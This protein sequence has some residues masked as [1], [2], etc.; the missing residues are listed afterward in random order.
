MRLSKS[1]V[2][3]FAAL[4]FG[5]IGLFGQTPTAQITGTVLDSSGAVVPQAEVK[6]TNID[7]NVVSEKDTSDDGA[8][9]IINLLPGNYVLTVEKAGFKTVALPTFQ[10]EVDQILTEKISMQVGSSAETVTVSAST[11]ATLVQRSTTELGTVIEEKPVESLPLNGRNFTSLLILTPGITPISTAQGSGITASDGGVTGIPGTALTKPSIQGQQNRSTI[12]LLDGINNTDFR[13]STYGIEPIVDTIDEFKVQSHNDMAEYGGVAGGVVNVATKPGTNSFHGAGWDFARS[14]IFDARNPF[15]D[16]C[17]SVRCGVGSSSSTPAPPLGYTQQEFGGAAGGPI[18]KNKTFFYVGYEGWRFSKPISSP[19]GIVPTAAELGG[20]FSNSLIG[21]YDATTKAVVPDPIYN[22]FA[23]GTTQF[24]CNS[25]GNPLPYNTT[26]GPG[27]G[28]QVAGTNCAKI[29]TGLINQQLVAA[30]KAYM[31][32]PNFTP[33]ASQEDNFFQNTPE[34]DN[35]NNWQIRLDEH[36]NDKNTVFLRLSQMWLTDVTPVVGNDQLTYSTYH[37]YNFGGAWDHVF[38]SN[39]I[40]EIRAGANFKPYIFYTQPPSSV[41]FSPETTAGFT[42]I[43]TTYG[44]TIGMPSGSYP[45]AGDSGPS[46]RGNPV[47]NAESSLSWIKGAHNLKMGV[48]YTYT[49]RL[50]TNFSQGLTFSA[51]QTSPANSSGNFTATTVTE[52]DGT[53]VP[54]G[55]GLASMLL[56][57]PSAASVSIPQYQEI[58]LEVSSWA[59]YVQDEWHV[60]PKLTVDWGLRYDY[61]PQVSV[62]DQNGRSMNMF[63]IPD[64]EYI[65]GLPSVGACSS[66]VIDPCIPGGINSPALTSV[67]AAGV[68]YNTTQNIVFS[69]KSLWPKAIGD[70]IGP[71]IGIAWQIKPNTVLRAGYGIYY[72][73]I[74]G[75]S[76]YSE[77]TEQGPV[78]PWTTGFSNNYNTTAGT[79]TNGVPLVGANLTPVVQPTPW[80]TTAGGYVNGPNYTDPRSQQWSVNLQRQLGTSMMFSVSYVGSKNNRLDYTGYANAADSATPAVTDPIMT[81]GDGVTTCGSSP[82]SACKLAYTAAIDTL[83]SVPFAQAGWHYSQSTGY[84]N[85]NALQAEFQRRF[86]NGLQA[87]ASY[88]WSKCLATSSGYFAAENGTNGGAVVENFFNPSLAYGPCGYDTPQYFTLSSVY[89]LP[90]GHGKA[91]LTHGPLSWVLGNWQTDLVFQARSGQNFQV[92]V[93]GDPANISGSSTTALSGYD[94][95]NLVANPENGNCPNGATVGSFQCWFNPSA[96]A[97]PDGQFGNFGVGVLRDQAFY[98]VDFSLVR[99]IPLTETKNIELRFEGFNV[100]NLQIL[101]T[102]AAT[103]G[104]GTPGLISSLASTPR[105]LQL[106][107]KFSF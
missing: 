66:S 40:F 10:L 18:I 55:N 77:N 32:T 21:T 107:A 51:N 101:G 25:M 79:L 106:A 72:D 1:V 4:L 87:I 94:R 63:D 53:K 88:T 68:T 73:T 7:T 12:Y 2:L 102:P 57:L 86:A 50:E 89:E 61:V 26:P 16:F 84:G 13:V 83:R 37:D 45:S 17:N 39:V 24:Q 23:G 82:S 100:F 105:E 54:T 90:F 76:Q 29:P 33:V 74:T 91:H 43:S 78:W 14:N 59:G 95:P 36:F 44:F 52:P 9:T 81:A 75:R 96:F 65:I 35:S 104:S 97:I 11:E 42:G 3:F 8:F 92:N 85:Y 67:T 6:V 5:C 71:R 48:Q 41:G 38:S 93:N 64:K 60:K 34:T 80:T 69:G 27:Y 46:D 15:T 30:Y 31:L 28:T 56:D 19:Y 103:I 62:I 70:N 22:P 20:D 58:F 98:D 99:N 47:A 49:N